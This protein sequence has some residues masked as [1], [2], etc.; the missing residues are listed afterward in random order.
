[1]RRSVGGAAR[2]IVDSSLLLPYLA[3]ELL[4]RL[5]LVGRVGDHL[6]GDGDL[7]ILQQLEG[8]ALLELGVNG[9]YGCDRGEAELLLNL[10]LVGVLQQADERGL[11]SGRRARIR[12][13]VFG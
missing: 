9:A 12:A 11:G 3:L 1:M 2:Q 7:L 8:A 10:R 4:A 6:H 13:R 5:A